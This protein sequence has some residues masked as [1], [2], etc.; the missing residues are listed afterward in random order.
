M[1]FVEPGGGRGKEESII[2]YLGRGVADHIKVFQDEALAIIC[3][4]PDKTP[5]NKR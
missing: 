2:I 4:L 1:V 5:L 3:P